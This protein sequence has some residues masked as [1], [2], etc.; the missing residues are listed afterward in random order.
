MTRLESTAD[1][2]QPY[3]VFKF[4][5]I[6]LKRCQFLSLVSA[7]DAISAFIFRRRKL[8]QPH[9][10]QNDWTNLTKLASNLANR[11]VHLPSLNARVKSSND[12]QS[13]MTAIV[14]R[15]FLSNVHFNCNSFP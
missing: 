9:S 1:H 12:D 5:Y 13:D 7:F 11:F 4:I 15:S 6:H 8:A 3:I 10:G 2:I 14:H